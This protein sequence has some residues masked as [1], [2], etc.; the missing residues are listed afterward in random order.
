MGSR[1]V[2]RAR[3]LLEKV[4]DKN[5][6]KLFGDEFCSECKHEKRVC[7]VTNRIRHKIL[8]V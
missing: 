2:P 6:V 5:V 8:Q 3:G 4:M 7:K 1:T